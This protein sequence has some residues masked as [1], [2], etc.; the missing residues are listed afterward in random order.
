MHTNFI[1]IFKVEFSEEVYIE[2]IEIYET[3]FAGGVIG[4]SA[5]NRNS[6]HS[7]YS[8]SAVVITQS[9]IFTP[10]FEV[11]AYIISVNYKFESL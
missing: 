11:N 3:Y 5:L 7:L 6:Y 4:I 9:R 2:K 1:L 10:Q 8:G